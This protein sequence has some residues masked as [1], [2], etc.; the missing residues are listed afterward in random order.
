MTKFRSGLG[1]FRFAC[2]L[3]LLLLQLREH[4]DDVR[5]RNDV[6]A[7]KDRPGFPAANLHNHAICHTSAAEVACS[8]T[9]SVVPQLAATSSA[10][11]LFVRDR[12]LAFPAEH[13]PHA[14]GNANLVPRFAEIADWLSVW[15][16]KHKILALLSA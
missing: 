10:L 5:L 7:V 4:I 11:A 15:T 2:I 16:G 9:A 13:A 3:V 8:G 12:C 1:L 14:S 6:V